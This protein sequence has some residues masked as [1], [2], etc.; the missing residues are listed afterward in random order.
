MGRMTASFRASL[1]PSSPA[2]S[3]HL[4]LGFSIT[5]A[6]AHTDRPAVIKTGNSTIK[7][8]SEET[9][10]DNNTSMH[11]MH[12]SLTHKLLLQFLLLWILTLTVTVTPRRDTCKK[13]K[14]VEVI[15]K[16]ALESDTSNRA[17]E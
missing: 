8:Q 6:P 9:L 14:E 17:E 15:I 5:I 13:H 10:D 7:R 11:T 16:P 3:F 2:T 1:A 4:T 12:T